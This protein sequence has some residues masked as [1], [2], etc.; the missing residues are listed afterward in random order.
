MHHPHRF[1]I[2]CDGELTIDEL[3]QMVGSTNAAFG[4]ASDVGDTV[5]L[6]KIL[7]L[8]NNFTVSWQEWSH[9]CSVW[10]HDLGV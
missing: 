10:L 9:A 5:N 2:D 8:D 6:L 7:D 4:L 3:H 1:D